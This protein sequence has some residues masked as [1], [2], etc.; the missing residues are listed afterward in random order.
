M[1]VLALAAIVIETETLS[2][3]SSER[4]RRI[5]GQMTQDDAA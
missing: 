3:Q 1:L 4:P 2:R 5:S